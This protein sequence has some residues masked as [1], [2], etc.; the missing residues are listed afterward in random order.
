MEFLTHEARLG[1]L[2]GVPHVGFAHET[3]IAQALLALSIP[4]DC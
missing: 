4:C 3:E 2:R 1:T